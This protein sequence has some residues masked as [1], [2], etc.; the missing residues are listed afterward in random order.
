MWVWGWQWTACVKGRKIVSCSD[1]NLIQFINEHLLSICNVCNFYSNGITTN[2]WFFYRCMGA[3]SIAQLFIT[4]IPTP[5]PG[6]P[7]TLISHLLCLPII[8]WLLSHLHHI[9]VIRIEG[10][11]IMWLLFLINQPAISNAVCLISSDL[12]HLR[13]P[14][15]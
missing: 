10:W 6:I 9:I 8:S 4:Y 13:K 14:G 1:F 7:D 11:D 2:D 12:A 15:A 3:T 5:P